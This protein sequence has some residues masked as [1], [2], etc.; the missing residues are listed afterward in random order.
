MTL[1]TKVAEV[2][3]F[4]VRAATDPLAKRLADIEARQTVPGP[5]GERGQDGTP[6]VHGKDGRDGISLTGG[7]VTQDG[8]LVLTLSD[9]TTHDVGPVVG[10]PGAK[11]ADG[12]TASAVPGLD[13]E[14]ITT[15][16]NMLLRKELA[17]LESAQ[18]PRI[19]RRVIR[20]ARGRIERV[21]EE[22]ARG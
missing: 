9:G 10:P 12:L 6:G 1:E 20:D 7:L 16:A 3:V 8:R 19:T 5:Q 14:V 11:G 21:I 18:P 15:S 17:A 13:A 22:P 4:A 2:V